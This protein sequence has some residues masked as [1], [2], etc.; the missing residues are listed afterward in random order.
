MYRGMVSR[1]TRGRVIAV[2]IRGLS[3]LDDFLLHAVKHSE[4][5][6]LLIFFF[7][8]VCVSMNTYLL[9][10]SKYCPV[11]IAILLL[12]FRGGHLRQKHSVAHSPV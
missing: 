12:L 8:F 5:R 11:A 6:R 3:S 2:W 10:N 4:R 7:F 1:L 9:H